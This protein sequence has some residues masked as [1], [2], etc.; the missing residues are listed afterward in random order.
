MQL[1]LSNGSADKPTTEDA[2]IIID[3]MHEIADIH[4]KSEREKKLNEEIAV[5]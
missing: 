3:V 5:S 1:V 2:R 4:A